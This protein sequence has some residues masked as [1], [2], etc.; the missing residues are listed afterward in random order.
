MATRQITETFAAAGAPPGRVLAV[1]GGTQNPVWLQA[2][3]DLTGLPQTVAGITLGAAYGDAFLAALAVGAA[4]PEAI[5]DWNPPS[6][7]ITPQH[8]PVYDRLYPLFRRLYAQ[9]R[10]IA[11][12]L[13]S[14]P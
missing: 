7:T 9:T 6:Q 14:A 3:S 13:E 4:K 11:A 12:E 10:D 8:H 5:S 2:T 1:G